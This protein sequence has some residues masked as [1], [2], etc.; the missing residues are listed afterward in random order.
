MTDENDAETMVAPEV[1]KVASPEELEEILIML[2]DI[3][4]LS[5]NQWRLLRSRLEGYL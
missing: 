1:L 2:D 4:A 3:T 5:S